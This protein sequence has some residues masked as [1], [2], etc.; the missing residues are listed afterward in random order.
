MPLRFLVDTDT[1]I[2]VRSK[3]PRVVARFEKLQPGEVG[4][5]VITYGE[6][7]YGV[8]RSADPARAQTNFERLLALLPVLPI[9]RKAG[10][11][12]GAV[13]ATLARAGET[14]GPNDIWIA[15]HALAA[16]LVLVTNNER[17]FKRVKDLK[18]E[19]WAK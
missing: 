3:H 9:E 8:H 6:L 2:Y 15:A 4:L 17:E 19:N 10:I 13:R 7:A 16:N 18:I 12:Y 14:I 5:S 1:C 11:H